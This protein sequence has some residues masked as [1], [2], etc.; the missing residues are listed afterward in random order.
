MTTGIVTP[1]PTQAGWLANFVYGTMGV[2]T[3]WLPSDSVYIGWAYNTAWATVNPAFQCVP[4]PIWLQ[5]IYNLAAHLLL[6]WTP[7]PNP[8]P[9]DPPAP[10]IIVDGTPYGFFQYQRKQNNVL[11]FVTGTVSASGDEGTNVSL[12]VPKQAENLTVGQMQLLSTFWGRTYLGIA[13]D[14]GTSWGL[15]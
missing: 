6:T 4:G 9:G 10:F 13:Q 8:Y 1:T 11:G 3:A 5:A 7:D 2:P 14:Y 15:N 12:V